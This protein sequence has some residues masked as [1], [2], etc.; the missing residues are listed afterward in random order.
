MRTLPLTVVLFASLSLACAGG[1]GADDTGGGAGGNGGNGGGNGG[2]GAGDDTGGDNGG[3]NGGDTEEPPPTWSP[4]EINF[5]EL[6]ND[7]PVDDVYAEWLT[8][9]VEER[10]TMNSW[11]YAS[12]AASPPNSAYTGTSPG[13]AGQAVNFWIHFARPVRNFQF[14]SLGDQTNGVYGH[15]DV[16][17]EDGTTGEKALRGDGGASSGEIQDFSQWEGIVDIYVRDITD[18]NTVNIDDLTFEIQDP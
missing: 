12:Y 16:T 14:T 18:A 9:E 11:N 5:D 4:V 15:A 10:C 8:F 13:G 6:R 17:L 1:K 2:N 3:D 7:Q